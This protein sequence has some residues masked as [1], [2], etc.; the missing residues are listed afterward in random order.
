MMGKMVLTIAGLVALL[1]AVSGFATGTAEGAKAPAAAK[2][3]PIPVKMMIRDRSSIAWQGS[4]LQKDI[5]ARFGILI[6][7]EVVEL[8]AY[9]EKF[10]IR[11]NS[12]DIPDIMNEF[13]VPEDQIN[14][15]G[16]KGMFLNY[17]DY[18]AETPNL[19][20]YLVDFKDD[21]RFHLSNRNALY[22]APMVLPYRYGY[23]GIGARKDLLD[24][25]GIDP[26]GLKTFDDLY[27]MFDSLKKGNG[28]K[29]V[30]GSRY[31]L[32]NLYQLGRF[33]G[34]S[35][36]PA[37][38]NAEKKAWDATFTL[39]AM[40]DFL[41]LTAKMYSAGI[42]HPD[43]LTMT[44]TEWTQGLYNGDFSAMVDNMQFITTAMINKKTPE[45]VWTHVIPPAY[46]GKR[47]PSPTL[48]HLQYSMTKLVNARTKAPRQIMRMIDWLYTWEG[49][50]RIQYG[51][52]GKDYVL[53]GKE[54][55]FTTNVSAKNTIPAKYQD[56][57][58]PSEEFL[59]R[60]DQ[61]P[62]NIYG[63]HSF[64]TMWRFLG[65]PTNPEQVIPFEAAYNDYIQRGVYG[66]PDP[67]TPFNEEQYARYQKLSEPVRTFAE[68][69]ISKII[70]GQV[71]VEEG[72]KRFQEGLAGFQYDELV[73]LYA[74]SYKT[75]SSKQADIR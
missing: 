20:K 18:L 16:D 37:T 59:K 65:R 34:V 5:A 38:W 67:G 19:K 53:I 52:E 14:N 75:F 12:G 4:E 7:T 56:R 30:L 15:A 57:L 69:N 2:T 11:F 60:Q 39:P 17:F 71:P 22:F 48:P 29:A 66:A 3:E 44:S 54:Q 6:D 55:W 31:K 1:S 24:K 49:F 25:A 10:R 74:E 70:L 9:A 61:L 51:V 28:G 63:L 8:A 27:A 47:I 21:L 50:Y 41:T 64:T 35:E 62:F 26:A 23:Y 43:F 68:E 72:W 40:K 32:G 13:G 33:M 36:S 46:G 42:L 45:A 58:M 73:A